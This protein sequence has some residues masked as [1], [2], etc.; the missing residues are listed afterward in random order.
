MKNL[1]NDTPKPM[2]CVLG[3]PLLEHHISFL[4]KEIDEVIFI[5]GYLGDQ[6]RSYFGNEWQGRKISYVEQK[7][8]NG[9]AGAIHLAKDMVRGKF[10]VTMG[11]DLYHPSDLEKLSRHPIALLGYHTT[12][13]ASF[14]IVTVDAKNRLLGVVERPHGFTE[15]LVNTGAYVLNADFFKYGPVKITE[16]EYGLP[17][18]LVVMS[19]DIPVTVEV[20]TRWQP[21]GNPD[22]IAFAEQFLLAL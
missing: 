11:D 12:N 18:T 8:L 3:K 19:R 5:I 7:E 20:T 6:I 1:T 2:L 9:T 21:V 14:G 15:G 13:A 17:Q 16:T 22:D 4:P 10:L